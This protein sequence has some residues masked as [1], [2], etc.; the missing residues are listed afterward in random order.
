MRK[1][2]LI[3][4][5]N[6]GTTCDKNC[7]IGYEYCKAHKKDINLISDNESVKHTEPPEQTEQDG[8]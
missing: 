6:K 8:S 3:R 4:G 2:I 5:K 1:K 7:F